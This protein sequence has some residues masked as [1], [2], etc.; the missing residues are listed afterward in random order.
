MEQNQFLK[1]FINMRKGLSHSESQ[2]K[3]IKKAE[4]VSD[5]NITLQTIIDNKPPNKDVIE[6]LR[7]RVEEIQ[8]IEE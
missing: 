3:T 1:S 8:M 2:K 7:R 6:Y 4:Y 5:G